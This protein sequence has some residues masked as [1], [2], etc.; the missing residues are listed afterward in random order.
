M[1]EEEIHKH[2]NKNKY[3]SWTG[4][5]LK[6]NV[7]CVHNGSFCYT[8][9]SILL[10]TANKRSRLLE[11]FLRFNFLSSAEDRSQSTGEKK[12]SLLVFNVE[13]L[14]DT[15]FC[16]EKQCWRKFQLWQNPFLLH[17]KTTLSTMRRNISTK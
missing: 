13:M 14:F 7:N 5:L 10:Q 12:I 9:C 17:L 1:F 2:A 3:L 11:S 8:Q 15:A 16:S 6:S 4:K